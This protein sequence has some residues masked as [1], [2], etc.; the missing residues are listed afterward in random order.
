MILFLF[1]ALGL[2]VVF[3]FLHGHCKFFLIF[4]WTMQFLK[5]LCIAMQILSNVCRG[6][7]IFFCFLHWQCNS[8]LFFALGMQ[9]FFNFCL[10]NADSFKLFHRQCKFF[11]IFALAMRFFFQHSPTRRF[12]RKKHNVFWGPNCRRLTYPYSTNKPI[13]RDFFLCLSTS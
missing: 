13:N 1:F 5:V 6:N 10:G 9:I 11:L 3:D 4:A 7:A 2:Q 12:S 8:F